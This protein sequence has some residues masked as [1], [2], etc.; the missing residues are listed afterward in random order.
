MRAKG[1]LG[2]IVGSKEA[3]EAAAFDV[4]QYTEEFVDAASELGM[5]IKRVFDTHIHADHISGGRQLAEE[6]SVPYHLG[7]EASERNPGF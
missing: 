4:S 7:S 5:K 3:G 2:Y 1:C 6:L